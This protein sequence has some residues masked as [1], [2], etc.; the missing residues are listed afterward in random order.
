MNS[1]NR[2]GL[3]ARMN[4]KSI[5]TTF[6]EQNDA[7]KT[8]KRRNNEI[9]KILRKLFE[10]LFK[11]KI[12]SGESSELVSNFMDR[13]HSTFGE[14]PENFLLTLKNTAKYIEIQVFF[15]YFFMKK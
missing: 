10:Q 15:Y 13:L 9:K 3:E 5:I 8:D 7:Q 1:T 6:Q 2:F 4:K 12:S 11:A 14:T